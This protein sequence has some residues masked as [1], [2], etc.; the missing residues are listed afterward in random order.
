MRKD[1][2]IRAGEQ[3]A[4]AL[5]DSGV[6]RALTDVARL[7][8]RPQ[9]LPDDLLAR[10]LGALR[11]YGIH[12]SRFTRATREAAAAVGLET[13][14]QADAW[15]RVIASQRRQQ[16]AVTLLERV[17]FATHHARALL[18][19]LDRTPRDRVGRAGGA[20]ETAVLS[21]HVIEAPN[22]FSTPARLAMLL[23]SVETLYQA[24]A[25]LEGAGAGGLSVVACDSGVD[26]TFD[27]LGDARAVT[28]MRD[29][30]LSLWDRVVFHR[31]LPPVERYKV[32]SATLPVLDEIRE[33]AA[34]GGLPPEEAELLRRR[35]I[36]STGRFLVAGATLPD[37][38]EH[39]YANP[40]AL[41][42]PAPKLIGPAIVDAS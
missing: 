15:S 17:R 30:L 23:Q 27:F 11:Q 38:R 41:M 29:V 32:A 28:R 8:S 9:P 33:R 34:T 1:E 21:V 12:A 31:A 36:E 16:E 7:G 40:R 26:K 42:A 35:V 24:C 22:R 5:R 6:E 2:L 3:L 4:A 14:D 18:G 37:L 20:A 19:L 13:L 10:L 25:T 39:A